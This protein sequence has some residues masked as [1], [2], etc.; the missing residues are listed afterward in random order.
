MFVDW[1]MCRSHSKA[2]ETCSVRTAN[3]P[4]I[5]GGASIT[6]ATDG[7]PMIFA[8]DQVFIFL[9]QLSF[10]LVWLCFNAHHEPIELTL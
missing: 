5:N 9:F 6:I 2:T 1:L 8:G 7:C 3:A 4:R 10:Q